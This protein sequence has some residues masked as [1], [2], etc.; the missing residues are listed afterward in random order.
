LRKLGSGAMGAVYEVERST[1]DA[2][3]ALKVMTSAS[4]P[5]LAARFARE[6]EVAAKVSH[7]NVVSIADVDVLDSGLPY[8]VM[9]LVAGDN[10]EDQ[11]ARW[12]EQSW[13]LGILA[14]VASGL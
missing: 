14:Q 11:R 4:T 5:E 10:L 6:A 8:L 7:E 2:R 3:F 1:D 9:E 12:G 13:A